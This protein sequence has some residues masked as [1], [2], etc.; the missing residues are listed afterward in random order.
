MKFVNKAIRG[1]CDNLFADHELHHDVL[2]IQNVLP[3]VILSSDDYITGVK[4]FSISFFIFY[5]QY[6]ICSFTVLPIH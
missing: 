6:F 2:L 5:V 3:A 1:T 4:T